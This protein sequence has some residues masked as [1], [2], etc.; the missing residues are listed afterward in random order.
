MRF[1]FMLFVLAVQGFTQMPTSVKAPR[2]L[3]DELSTMPAE[4]GAA[5]AMFNHGK[6][7]TARMGIPKSD[8]NVVEISGA[9]GHSW[10][11]E[12]MLSPD[13]TL[14]AFPY[15]EVAPCPSWK[16][17]DVNANQHYFLAVAHTDGSGVQKYPQILL[18][19]QMCWTRDNSKLAMVARME[20]DSQRQLVVDRSGLRR[21]RPRRRWEQDRGDAAVLVA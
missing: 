17:C 18:P 8:W 3:R 2:S 14:A 21:G 9:I 20:N 7:M 16:N 6:L 4:T 5:V 12:G 19:S 11:Y 15:W 1:I 13:G 10:S